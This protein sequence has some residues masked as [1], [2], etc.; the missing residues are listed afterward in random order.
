MKY[1]YKSFTLILVIVALIPSVEVRSVTEHKNLIFGSGWLTTPWDQDN[2]TPKKSNPIFRHRFVL[3]SPIKFATLRISGLGHYELYL[4]G[5]KVGDRVLDPSFTNYN[6]TVMYA[7]YRLRADDFKDVNC[8]GL[9]VGR[10]RYNMDTESGWN[11]Q[12]ASWRGPSCFIMQLELTHYDGSTTIIDGDN[13]WS[14]RPGPIYRDSMYGGEG[15]DAGLDQDGWLLAD[16]VETDW[17]KAISY[18]GPKGTLIPQE[19]EAVRITREICPVEIRE[20]PD[21]NTGNT[22]YIVDFGTV[23]SGTVRLLAQA[24]KGTRVQLQ[25]AETLNPDGRLN[26]AQN[27]V[28]GDYFQQD[29]YIFSGKGTEKWAA[30]FSYKGFRYVEVS[31]WVGPLKQEHL[32]A[33]MMHDDVASRGEFTCS[34]ELV[35][36][37]HHASRHALMLNVLHTVTDT[38]TYEKNGWTGDAQLSCLMGLYNFEME[39]SYRKF[40]ADMRDSQLETGEVAPIVPT[41][42]WGLTGSPNIRWKGITGATPAWDAALFEITWEVYRFSGNKEI[43]R[44]NYSA[45]KSYLR[46]LASVAEDFIVTKGLGDWAPVSGDAK[47]RGRV[48]PP[49]GCSLSSTAYFYHLTDLLEKTA[50][51]LDYQYDLKDYTDLKTKIAEAFHRKFYNAEKGYYETD[52]PA[53]FRQTSNVLPLAFGLVPADKIKEVGQHLI[54]DV[55]VTKNHHLDS[56]ILGVRYLLPV[57]SELGAADVAYWVVTQKT[58]P[59]WGYWFEIGQTTLGE[60]W[61][62]DSRTWSHHMFGSVG[63]WFYKYLAGINISKSGNEEILISPYVPSDLRQASASVVL[64]AGTVK[65]AWRFNEDGW[66]ISIEIPKGMKGRL[67]LPKGVPGV[68]VDDAFRTK[69]HVLSEGEQ[70]IKFK[71]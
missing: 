19:T 40:L 54:H 42:G 71:I 15:H 61:S 48:V 56:G 62:E 53:G 43:L 55:A 60:F 68:R 26:Y 12:K 16:Y 1:R 28:K 51:A 31:N 24:P 38:P 11:F 5:K 13:E 32:T 33:L 45:M 8:L 66:E 6:K 7:T 65:S 46:F 14:C 34:N 30:R 25:Y 22:T 50:R 37:I 44:E 2:G 41:S 63:A 36:Q 58:Y 21:S 10:G 70:L 39:K 59:S 23:L 69:G 67:L 17:F 57:L 35:N 27:H 47:T 4:N 64:P 18:S 3:N 49:E 52:I 9:Y 20:R 29:E